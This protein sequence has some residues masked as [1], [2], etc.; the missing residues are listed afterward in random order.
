MI[1]ELQREYRFEAAHRLS[2]VPAHHKCSRLHGHNYTVGITAQG[3][4]D[5]ATGWL[6]DFGALDKLMAPLLAQLD[7]HYLNEIEGLDNPT[8]EVL[9]HWLW[10]RLAPVLPSLSAIS[11]AET[12]DSRCIY[13]GA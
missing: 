11:V 9:A 4:V 5:P 10:L 1:V 8:S 12:N 7:H 2:A 6:I 13:R 3:E